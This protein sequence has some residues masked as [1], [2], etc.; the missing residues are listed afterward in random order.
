MLAKHYGIDKDYTG[1]IDFNTDYLCGGYEN[2]TSEM[3][4][5]LDRVMSQ[6]GIM[7]DTTYLGKAFYGMMDSLKKN[8]RSRSP[9]LAYWRNNEFNEMN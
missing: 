5:Y 8:S 3:S 7:F 2:H 4:E 9:F 6:T 1:L